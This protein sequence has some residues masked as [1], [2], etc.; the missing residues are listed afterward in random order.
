[1]SSPEG[2]ALPVKILSTSI[3][4]FGPLFINR[5]DSML[6]TVA[7]CVE[8]VR[9]SMGA[10]FIVAGPCDDEDARSLDVFFHRYD[11]PPTGRREKN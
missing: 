8:R 1:M 11:L 10:T 7:L 9:T 3:V 2:R 4:D 6:E 5:P